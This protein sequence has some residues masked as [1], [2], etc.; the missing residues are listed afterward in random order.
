MLKPVFPVSTRGVSAGGANPDNRNIL[1]IT[2][3]STGTQ[4]DSGGDLSSNCFITEQVFQI[5]QEV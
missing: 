2:F 5:Q 3:A 1:F 4:T